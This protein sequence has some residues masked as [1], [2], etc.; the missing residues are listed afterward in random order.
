MAA[1]QEYKLLSLLNTPVITHFHEMETSIKRYAADW[2]ADVLQHS[3]HFIACSRAVKDNLVKTYNVEPTKITTSY[4][5]ITPDSS[6]RILSDGEKWKIRKKLGV[7]TYGLLVF[8][9]GLGMAFRKGADIFIEVARILRQKGFDNFHFYWIGGFE[10]TEKDNRFGRWGKHLK[11]LKK[12]GLDSY[13]TFLGL[14]NNPREYL[15]AGDLFL[16]PSR[17]DPFPLVA[18]EAA[19]WGLPVICFADAGGMPDFVGEDAGFVVPHGDVEAM[20]E[21]VALLMGNETLMGKLGGQARD[22][23]LSGFT[24]EQTTP[25]VLSA[26]RRVAG[27]KPAVSVIVPNFNHAQYL[28]RRLDS[29]FSQTAKDIEVII[30]DDASNDGSME[31]INKYAQRLDVRVLRN[32]ENSGSPFKQWLK[33]IDLA[34]AD[35]IWI[36]ES[37]DASEPAFL[38]TLL[39]AFSDPEVKLAYADS[40]VIDENG[41]V[42]GNYINCEYLTSLS[43]TKW[44]KGYKTLATDE[45]ND[46]LGV[47]N[48]ILNAS[49]VLFRKFKLTDESANTLRNMRIAGD[50]YFIINA[51]KNGKVY[52][53]NSRLNYHRRHQNSVIGKTLSDKKLEEFF[54]EYHIVHKYIFDNYKLNSNFREKW[55]NY[56]RKQWNDF[57]PGRPFDEI[58]GYYPFADVARMLGP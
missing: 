34:Q 16:L 40:H 1:G 7:K 21:K 47:K 32:E 46:G 19:E 18:L 29:I 10:T 31:V 12:Y 38:E 50:W 17:E 13:V 24:F 15:R 23:L 54:R 35:I 53:D 2:I 44:R 43:A 27:K 39:P 52:Y 49:A 30:L 6:A 22:K 28:P 45:I 56:L 25:N 51:I 11:A 33:G 42:T 9:C 58:E 41:T 37:D 36:A 48:T 55:E 3:S 20:A 26:C 5:S 8:G 57:Y 14:K 4:S